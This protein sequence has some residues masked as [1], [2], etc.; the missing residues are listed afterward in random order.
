M[1][2]KIKEF[3]NIS[4]IVKF[5]NKVY[6]SHG[7]NFIEVDSGNVIYT[8]ANTDEHNQVAWYFFNQEN[9]ATYDNYGEGVLFDGLKT[10]TISHFVIKLLKNEKLFCLDNANKKIY[11]SDFNFNKL[12]ELNFSLYWLDV[13]ELPILEI[14]IF[15]ARTGEK[16]IR[17]EARNIKDGELK[18]FL[19]FPNGTVKLQPITE[20]KILINYSPREQ[21]NGVELIHVDAR[22]GTVISRPI[23]PSIKLPIR[24]NIKRFLGDFQLDIRNNRIIHPYAEFDLNTLQMYYRDFFK[25]ANFDMEVVG[26]EGFAWNEDYLFFNAHRHHE[27]RAGGERI[28][29]HHML[30]V[31]DRK[32]DKMIYQTEVNKNVQ[33]AGVK[34]MFLL[35]DRLYVL[36]S[37]K[38]LVVY[39]VI[40]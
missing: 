23:L 4:S 20:D 22:Q 21:F 5:K 14:L 8:F 33:W 34:Q 6:G 26:D 32:A 7:I 17:I 28:D 38:V 3:E 16:E 29:Y 19:E 15:R 13:I 35:E 1:L 10:R 36:D 18:W 24:N 2:Q 25:N 9:L 39:K 31:L 40:F 11:L 37:M 30:T 12:W 27:F